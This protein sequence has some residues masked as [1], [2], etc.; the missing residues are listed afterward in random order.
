MKKTTLTTLGM[1]LGMTSASMSFAADITVEI[2]PLPS[3][4]GMVVVSL[5]DRAEGFPSAVTYGQRVAASR[6][7]AGQPLRIV[8]TDLPAGRYAIVAYQDEDGNGKLTTNLMGIP[9]E[10]MGFSNKA[11]ASFGPPSFDSAAIK[12]GAQGTTVRLQLE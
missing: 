11:K 12:V 6:Q 8:F 5:F 7:V 10:A 2:L 9:T 4:E 3:N 1:L